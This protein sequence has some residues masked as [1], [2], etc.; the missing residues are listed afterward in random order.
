MV[1]R[2][3]CKKGGKLRDISHFKKY[4][5]LKKQ[6]Y[7][8]PPHPLTKEKIRDDVNREGKDLLL[9]LSRIIYDTIKQIEPK[10]SIG[11]ARNEA[12]F[13]MTRTSDDIGHV[14]VNVSSLTG[15][16]PYNFIDIWFHKDNTWT[17][18]AFNKINKWMPKKVKSFQDAE[19]F[20]KKLLS[21]GKLL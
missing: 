10:A 5:E 16:V 3:L 21:D 1:V 7:K 2:Y 20:V 15:D 14:V 4:W 13:D 19:N 18:E 12:Y 6:Q 9:S 8:Q 17:V 11:I